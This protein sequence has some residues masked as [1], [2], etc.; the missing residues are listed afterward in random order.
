MNDQAF[1]NMNALLFYCKKALHKIH[2]IIITS[3]NT[4]S[5]INFLKRSSLNSSLIK[6]KPVRL[7]LECFETSLTAMMSTIILAG[8][9]K[10]RHEVSQVTANSSGTLPN[11]PETDRGSEP[12]R[13]TYELDGAVGRIISKLED[14]IFA[15][16]RAVNRWKDAERR[17]FNDMYV[18]YMILDNASPISPAS[19]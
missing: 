10:E 13:T 11:D 14:D 8:R 17:D 15:N 7:N 9:R 2:S 5:R 18:R 6:A 19:Q 12:S 3:R 1:E 16:L 4:P